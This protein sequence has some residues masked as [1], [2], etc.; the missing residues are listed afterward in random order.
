MNYIQVHA[1]FW[2]C[3]MPLGPDLMDN[4]HT[5]SSGSLTNVL[6]YYDEVFHKCCFPT[7]RKTSRSTATVNTSGFLTTQHHKAKFCPLG[8]KEDKKW[9]EAKFQSESAKRRE[10]CESGVRWEPPLYTAL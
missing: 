2:S 3:P 5:T 10:Q 1:S 6:E 8:K 9:G 7:Q 4:K